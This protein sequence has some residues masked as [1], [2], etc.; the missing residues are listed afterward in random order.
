LPENDER[1]KL[2]HDWE[3]EKTETGIYRYLSGRFFSLRAAEEQV[4]VLRQI[5]YTDAF[6]APYLNGTQRITMKEYLEQYQ[7]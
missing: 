7:K 5:G 3:I 6:I 2:V 1:L 4:K